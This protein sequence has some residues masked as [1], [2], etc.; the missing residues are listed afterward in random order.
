MQI[1]NNAVVAIHYTLKNNKGDVIDSSRNSDPLN[2][3]HGHGNIVPGLEKALKGKSKGETLA[4][5]VP[6]EEGY[7]LRLNDQVQQIPRDQFE[8]NA[9]IQP[10]MQFQAQSPEG[11]MVVTVTNV[12]DQHVTVDGN[13]PLAGEILNFDIEV[14]E[15]REASKEEISHGHVHGKGVHEH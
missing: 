8:A 3:L 1:T 2:Y 13:H 15:V 11:V 7:G 10:G 6:P 4:V 14:M 5:I 9:D 12:D